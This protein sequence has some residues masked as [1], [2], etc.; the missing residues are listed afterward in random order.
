MMTVARRLQRSSR[1]RP[2]KPPLR[3]CPAQ[4]CRPSRD[5]RY[6]RDD[7]GEQKGRARTCSG[8]SER[9]R[10]A[11]GKAKIR[12]WVDPRARFSQPA[13]TTDSLRSTKQ[14]PLESPATNLNVETHVGV[15]NVSWLNKPS[16]GR[17]LNQGFHELPMAAASSI[18]SGR[19]VN[20]LASSG[21]LPGL[22]G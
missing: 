20:F 2:R 15:T 17:A 18:P 11:P 6:G 9:R 13:P 1:P 12:S 21:L 7:G 4:G 22:L 3:H 8:R 14:V 16:D 5:H 19:S 10:P